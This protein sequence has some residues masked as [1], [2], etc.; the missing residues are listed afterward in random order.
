MRARLRQGIGLGMQGIARARCSSCLDQRRPSH[1]LQGLQA[2]AH[3]A[4]L[5]RWQLVYRD[6]L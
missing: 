2:D 5:A 1:S 6:D 4:R 3:V